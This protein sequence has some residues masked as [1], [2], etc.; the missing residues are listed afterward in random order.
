MSG[1][2][3]RCARCNT[4]HEAIGVVRIKRVAE[5]VGKPINQPAAPAIVAS[6]FGIDVP[7]APHLTPRIVRAMQEG[8]YEGGEVRTALANIRPGDRVLEL[9]AGS[10]AVGAAIAHNCQPSRIVSFEANPRLLPHARVLYETN[11]LSDVIDLR[12]GVV[13]SEPDAPAAVSFMLRGNFLGSALAEVAADRP[14]EKIEVPVTRYADL[15]RDFPHDVIVMDIEGAEHPFFAGA[16]L[17]AVRV[18]LVELHPKVYGR[19]GARECR[20]ML[21][22][23][24][25]EL[26][27]EGSVR[28]VS[29]F[30]RGGGAA[31]P[32]I[33]GADV[34]RAKPAAPKPRPFA[35]PPEVGDAAEGAARDA[36]LL[37]G[38]LVDAWFERRSDVL[39]V[40]FDNLASVAEYDPPQPWLHVRAGRAGYSILGLIA[41]RKDW[42]RNADAPALLGA[43]RD[44][45]LFGQFRRVV[46]AGASMGGY[47]ALTYA[48]F[49][50]GCRVLAFSPQTTLSRR[51][52]PFE[53]RFPYG[54]RKW[55]WDSPDFL[56]AVEGAGAASEIRLVYDPFDPADR[57]HA[58]RLSHLSSVRHMCCGHFGHRTIRMIDA[59]GALDML[60]T[61]A[62][63]D[64]FDARPFWQALRARRGLRRWRLAVRKAVEARNRPALLARLDKALAG[65]AEVGPRAAKRRIE[66]ADD[67]E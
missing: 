60:I 10:G 37:R 36:F 48:P 44:A 41:H 53:R 34:A 45:G 9:G 51:V 11:G 4:A 2:P 30:R 31:T 59:A 14:A 47:A 38:G 49:A 17:S 7:E 42:Y 55:D 26:D 67:A 65:I 16:D 50:P 28:G 21:T 62:G 1:C 56:D 13:L 15:A 23:A 39:L 43:L 8:R 33:P 12:H 29:V 57:A 19:D 35:P 3:V 64:T 25:F 58:A 6:Y 20:R 54:F 40:T 22:R 32:D 61:G 5:D 18:V 66:E 27:R 46:F 52:A 63:Q 24:G